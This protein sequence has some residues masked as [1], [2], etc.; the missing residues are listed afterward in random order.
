MAAEY[1]VVPWPNGAATAAAKWAFAQWLAMR[2][3]A[4]SYEDCAAIGQVRRHI[5][6]GGESRFDPLSE[7]TASMMAD[8]DRRPVT[9][10]LG[11]RKGEG[12]E[13]RWFIFPEA[14]RKVVCAGFDPELVAA[15]LVK[16][17]MLERGDAKHF[18]KLVKVQGRPTRFYVLTPKI[19]EGDA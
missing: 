7:A 19:L 3:G 13:Q 12:A 6:A 1:G 11:Y 16:L 18:T 14:F 2:G 15:T 10:R 8:P 5:E 9:D 17:G 4:S